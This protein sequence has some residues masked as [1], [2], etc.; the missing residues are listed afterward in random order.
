MDS[1]GATAYVSARFEQL[2]T[3]GGI[4]NTSYYYFGAQRVAMR[5]GGA[6]YWIHGDH[7][8]SASLTT[9]ANGQVVSEMRFY[10]FGETR[11]VSGTMP[12]NRTYTGQLAEP[13]GLGSLMDYNA[14][15]YSPLLGRFISADTIVPKPGIQTH[16]I[17]T[18]MWKTHLL[19]L[20]TS[21]DTVQEVYQTVTQVI[22]FVGL[23]M[24][25]QLRILATT[26]MGSINGEIMNYQ[27]D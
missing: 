17:A 6:V 12:T 10:P 27:I 26:P 16:S 14:R 20:W 4:T 22:A 9:D 18:H 25:K 15:E 24:T 13:N 8:G 21:L 2:R 11:W 19:V 7:L 5:T 23:Y 3:S 1:A